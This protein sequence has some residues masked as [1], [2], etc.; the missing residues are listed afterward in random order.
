MHEFQTGIDEQTFVHP[1][2]VTGRAM[3]MQSSNGVEFHM[4]DKAR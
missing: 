1:K 2:F 3:A 4:L